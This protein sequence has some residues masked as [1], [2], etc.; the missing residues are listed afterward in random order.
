MSVGG[1]R[2]GGAGWNDPLYNHQLNAVTR[3][4]YLYQI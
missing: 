1:D 2:Q 4:C 3:P